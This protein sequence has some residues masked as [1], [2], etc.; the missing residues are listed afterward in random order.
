MS[1]RRSASTVLG[2]VVAISF[3]L[4]PGESVQVQNAAPTA[5]KQCQALSAQELAD[6][7]RGAAK[8]AE[9]PDKFRFLPGGTPITVEIS[10]VAEKNSVYCAKF[11][12]DDREV[13]V[14]KSI[15]GTGQKTGTTE[16][17]LEVPESGFGWHRQRTLALVTFPSDSKGT[18]KLDS[19]DVG[20]T[21]NVNVSDWGF[22]LS[23]ALG[24]V[25]LGYLIAVLTSRV[26]QGR[27]IFDPVTLTAGKGGK[28]SLS[29]LQIFC[30]T[31]IVLGMLVYVLL[32]IGLFSGI[33]ED[34][35]LLLGISAVGTAGSKVAD[36]MKKRLS[37]ENWSWLRNQGWLT[38]YEEGYSP[39]HQAPRA[40]WGDLLKTDG[41]LDVYSF[42][43]VTF[44]VIV[45]IA[46]ILTDLSGLASFTLPQNILALLG[47]S[48]VVYIGGKVIAPS[49]DELNK[50]MDLLRKAESD[51]FVQAA[52]IV[53]PLAEQPAKQQAAK[54]A[55]PALYQAYL[56]VARDAARMLKTVYGAEGTKFKSEPIQDSD[57]MPTF[58]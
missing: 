35:L 47:L 29:K 28:A 26:R 45:A 57:L 4:G 18:L 6:K 40:N 42:Q 36:V 11:L 30:F 12:E 19:P 39:P 10:A 32:R 2:V 53:T 41:E 17:T 51:W 9:L 38:V 44:S 5:A 37:F 1:I 50:K 24:V 58:P 20:L 46:L 8:T 21:Q 25:A 43:L 33:S 48:N 13:R 3:V 56:T 7:A 22:A 15:P 52:A 23:M 16:V 54:T 34:I 14:I 27:L 55:A 49:V 31:L